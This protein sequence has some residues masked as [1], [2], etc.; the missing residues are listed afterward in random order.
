MDHMMP[1]M[2]GIETSPHIRALDTT[3]AKKIP[4]VALTANT[5]SGDM[6]MFL[7]NGIDDFLSKP[8]EL[9]KLNRILEKWIPQEKQVKRQRRDRPADAVPAGQSLNIHGVDTRRGQFNTGGTSKGYRSILSIFSTEMR[10]NIPRIQE[11]LETRDYQLYTTLV[12]ALKGS[13]RSIG[14]MEMGDAA[15]ELEDAGRKQ[16]ISAMEERT[17]LLITLLQELIERITLALE[18]GEAKAEEISYSPRLETLKT[19]LHNSDYSTVDQELK[20]LD[21]IALDKKTRE[22]IENIERDV[23]LFEYEK[24]AAR[25]G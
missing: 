9:R 8:I 1:G 10:S 7:A 18:A 17:G 20:R 11:A 3:Y 12:H 24:A 23:L 2:D 6:N 21:S 19:A 25:L 14:A 16:N 15:A 4:I 22:L 13:S 5:M